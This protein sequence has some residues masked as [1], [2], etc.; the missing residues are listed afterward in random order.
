MAWICGPWECARWSWRRRFWNRLGRL[1]SHD[2]THR[3]DNFLDVGIVEHGHAAAARRPYARIGGQKDRY[4]WSSDCRGQMRDAGIVAD[5]GAC[6]G[7]PASEV[8]EIVEAHGVLQWLFRTSG[9]LHRY[10]E[11]FHQAPG[12]RPKLIDGPAFRNAAGKRVD[13]DE[14]LD[15]DLRHFDA[16]NSFRRR[17]QRWKERE[18]QMAHSLAEFRPVRAV[19]GVNGVEG[20][21]RGFDGRQASVLDYAHQVEARVGDG[22]GAIRKANQR[23]HCA[24]GPN[25]GVIRAGSFERGQGKDHVA[26]GARPDKKAPDH[27]I[28]YKARALSRSTIRAS[29]EARARVISP[30][31]SMPVSAIARAS[32]L[33][34]VA[35]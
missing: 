26:D 12:D 1:V 22:A 11:L 7:E 31:R 34:V 32:L 17:R 21:E 8:V 29:S 30:S 18:R 6:A 24:S 13:H 5:I 33:V 35:I 14:V 9:P 15:R 2:P 10:T 28:L 3:C 4:H 20:F 19:P 25:L 27:L 16:R 23:Q